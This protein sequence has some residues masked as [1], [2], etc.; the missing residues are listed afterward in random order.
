MRICRFLLPSHDED[1]TRHMPKTTENQKGG[2]DIGHRLSTPSTA[3]LAFVSLVLVS[4][5]LHTSA[6]IPKH[7]PRT[8]NLLCS[9]S[10]MSTDN[11]FHRIYNFTVQEALKLQRNNSDNIISNINS[12]VSSNVSFA[13]IPSSAPSVAE[14]IPFSLPS[15]LGP[16]AS[17]SFSPTVLSPPSLSDSRIGISDSSSN[18]PF[19]MYYSMPQRILLTVSQPIPAVLS[20]FGAVAI[21]SFVAADRG[22]KLSRVYHRLLAAMSIVSIL[23]SFV[24]IPSTLMVPDHDVGRPDVIVVDYL[25]GSIGS[26]TTCQI[27]GCV[28][29]FTALSLPSYTSC[30]SIYF[31]LML[32]FQVKERT[33]AK[34][35]EPLFHLV[36]VGYPL[37]TTLYALHNEYFN[38]LAIVQGACWISEYPPR[39][40]MRDDTP[41]TRGIGVSNFDFRFSACFLMFASVLM[42]INMSIIYCKVRRQERTVERRY[43]ALV[44]SSSGHGQNRAPASTSQRMATQA[45]LYNGAFF[46]NYIS[47]ILLA[48]LK[49][50]QIPSLAMYSLVLTAKLFFPMQGFFLCCIYVRPRIQSL[51]RRQPQSSKFELFGQILFHPKRGSSSGITGTNRAHRRRSSR[52]SDFMTTSRRGDGDDEEANRSDETFTILQQRLEALPGRDSNNQDLVPPTEQTQTRWYLPWIGKKEAQSGLSRQPPIEEETE[53]ETQEE[54]EDPRRGTD[55]HVP[56][57][58]V[59]CEGIDNSDHM[60]N[61]DPLAPPSKQEDIDEAWKRD[62]H[63]LS[64]SMQDDMSRPTSSL[65]YAS[66]TSQQ[67]MAAYYENYANAYYGPDG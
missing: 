6:R 34:Y 48:F 17:A 21:L 37:L 23:M 26:W 65:S 57:I 44:H 33:I 27:Q 58:D 1:A 54:A 19:V 47:M 9:S 8:T 41:C 4:V 50:S 12:T 52:I 39:C 42:F 59:M 49:D 32:R 10:T 16:T 18:I 35:C 43:T 63:T 14:A 55:D 62:E 11:V 20:L 3:I 24:L 61:L 13:S 29:H 45:F 51:Q 64:S 46:V 28:M 5:T 60:R 38:P 56:G 25:W 53:E 31:L 66:R 7:R 2:G 30:L 40:S 22:H 36:S 15:P 67:E